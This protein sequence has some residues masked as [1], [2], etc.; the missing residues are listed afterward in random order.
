[1]NNSPDRIKRLVIVGVG[2]IGGSLASSLKKLHL[3]DEIIGVGRSEENL[4]T[5]HKMGLLDLYL[6]DPESIPSDADMVLIAVPVAQTKLVFEVV[7]R[8][9]SNTAIIT[10]VGST[11]EDIISIAREALGN[12]FG[13]FVPAHPIAGGEKNGA[14]AASDDLFLDKNVVLTPVDGTSESAVDIVERMWRSV[15]A[16][17]IRLDAS[18]HDVIFSAV[19]HLPHVVSFALVSMLAARS[20]S[21]QLFSFAASGFRDFSRIAGSSPEMWKDICQSNKDKVLSDI[22]DFKNVLEKIEQM[23]RGGDFGSLLDMFQQASDARNKW[24]ERK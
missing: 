9:V 23:M 1:M 2:L 13:R 16:N 7:A 20:D 24:A 6:T 11:K 3:V 18:S 12:S 4:I 14:I 17:I 22:S 19:S 15:G 10:D 21:Q 8:K 5:A